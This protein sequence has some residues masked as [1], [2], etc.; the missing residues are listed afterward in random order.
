[1]ILVSLVIKLSL[2]SLGTNKVVLKWI[3]SWNAVMIDCL[4]VY[5]L[6]APHSVWSCTWW[7]SRQWWTPPTSKTSSSP[8]APSSPAPWRS[9]RSC[10]SG[11]KSTASETRCVQYC[12]CVCACTCVCVCVCVVPASLCEGVGILHSNQYNLCQVSVLGCMGDLSRPDTL[13]VHKWF[14]IRLVLCCQ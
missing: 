1:M 5:P 13:I 2:L 6:R 10:S 4:F 7:R 8:T 9:A 3:D 14:N 12:V 11:S